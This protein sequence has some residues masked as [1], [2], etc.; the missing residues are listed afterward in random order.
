M[1]QRLVEQ[2]HRRVADQRAGQRDPLLLPA[3]QRG[4]AA[5]E[6]LGHPEPLGQRAPPAVRV[7]HPAGLAARR[8]CSPGRSA[9]GRARSSRTRPRC[10]ACP[11]AG[12]ARPGADADVAGGGGLQAG[13]HPQRGGL[14]AARGP[15][16]GD[17][18][19]RFRRPGR[20]PVPPRTARARGRRR[21][22]AARPGRGPWRAAP[23]SPGCPPAEVVIA[24]SWAGCGRSAP[25]RGAAAAPSRAVSSPGSPPA[26]TCTRSSGTASRTRSP[27]AAA[28]SLA[29]TTISSAPPMSTLSSTRRPRRSARR[30]LPGTASVSARSGAA[31]RRGRLRPGQPEVAGAQAEPDRG[32]RRQAGLGH[33]NGQGPARGDDPA[34]HHLAV[35][36]VDLRLAERLGGERVHRPRPDLPAAC[37]P[38]PAPP[39]AGCRSGRRGRAPP[40]SRG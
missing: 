10:S 24:S 20:C 37:R 9:A 31:V 12:P 34:V 25:V 5:V 16:D 40:G 26:K 15:E 39:I 19:A 14:P 17:Q 36:Q 32:A 22:C 23:L 27:S 30:T 7:L 3:G 8:R 11:A 18:L 21:S 13:D 33:R 6:Q 2:Q 1:G 28:R 29:E 35:E 4:R 38:G